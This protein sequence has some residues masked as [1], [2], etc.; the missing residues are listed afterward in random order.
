[1]LS[2]VPETTP[3]DDNEPIIGPKPTTR[4]VRRLTFKWDGKGWWDGTYSHVFKVNVSTG[5]A[6]QMTSG[7]FDHSAPAWSPDGE[8]IAFAAN[9]TPEP[10]YNFHEDIFIV[11]AAG[12]EIRKLTSSLGPLE[13]PV[14][15]KDG[16]MI[17]YLGHDNRHE[18]ATCMGLYTVSTSGVK[19]E[20]VLE[21][22]DYPATGMCTSD[23]V[24]TR[25]ACAP[26]F[27]KN[28]GFLF[29]STI[30]GSQQ[31]QL[32]PEGSTRPEPIAITGPGQVVYDMS[33]C[34]KTGGLAYLAS[35]SRN[36]GD[37]Y[38]TPA[39]GQP[40]ERLTYT[41]E[42]FLDARHPSAAE[43]FV[44]KGTAG[45]DV[46][47]WLYK[48]SGFDPSK[49]YPAVMYIH[50]GSNPCNG[51][52]FNFDFQ[53]LASDGFIV[54]A[55]NQRGSQGYGQEKAASVKHKWCEP[56]YEDLMCGINQVAR[57]PY[58]DSSRLGV[59]GGS[60]GGLLT[61]WIVT[62]SDLFAAA[63][64][65]R[66]TSNRFS[67]YGTC[68]E[69]PRISLWVYPCDPWDDPKYYM[70][71]SPV[72]FAREVT[73]PL[74]I[75]HSEEDYRCNL[76]QAE[77]FYRALK[78]LRKTVEMV[79]FKGECHEMNRSGRPFNRVEHTRQMRRW[80]RKYLA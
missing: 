1:V 58:V 27:T 15:S 29:L 12:G 8:W 59:T 40:P 11:P 79:I 68:D 34:P 16:S 20:N 64:T 10:D 54:F 35:D 45:D 80:F 42:E 33:Y 71:R 19:E 49:K 13:A 32:L 62:H 56:D 38:Y 6:S 30:A 65:Q 57:L 9:R 14:W 52:V 61:N 63:V 24:G 39:V 25:G 26:I 77:Q 18:R 50:G 75:L 55:P 69:G 28:G 53:V 21:G 47:G 7:D 72:I 23:S 22:Y 74:L 41:N 43:R 17:A 2:K 78:R 73:T 67:N 70:D 36:I 44:F 48:P 51:Y 66:S 60:Y 4:V 76:E 37:L 5:A 31:I 46:E 3:Y